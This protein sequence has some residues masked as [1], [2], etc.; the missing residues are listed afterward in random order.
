MGF[1]ANY[2]ASFTTRNGIVGPF[3]FRCEEDNRWEAIQRVIKT[4]Y[5]E[6]LQWEKQADGKAI[7]SIWVS[8]QIQEM[9]ERAK[10]SQ[11]AKPDNSSQAPTLEGTSSPERS[12][13]KDS[14]DRGERPKTD[15]R[16]RSRGS[17]AKSEASTG[18]KTA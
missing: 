18:T 5:A 14:S 17:S 1:T 12:E 3:E 6:L 2:C 11:E 16:K 10:M 7:K 9:V 8:I 13:E 4:V 15:R